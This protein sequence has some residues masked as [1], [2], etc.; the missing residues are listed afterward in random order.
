MEAEI[1]TAVLAERSANRAKSLKKAALDLLRARTQWAISSV[2]TLEFDLDVEPGCEFVVVRTRDNGETEYV[3]VEDADPETLAG[4]VKR[5][6]L[7]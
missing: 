5:M 7:K 6:A 2:D 4:V 3:S 1:Y